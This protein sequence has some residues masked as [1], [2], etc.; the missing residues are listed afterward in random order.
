MVGRGHHAAQGAFGGESGRR[1]LP[2]LG[3]PTILPDT[4]YFRQGRRP[5]SGSR[6]AWHQCDDGTRIARETGFDRK[7][8]SVACGVHV[9]ARLG[10]GFI[11]IM[12]RLGNIGY[13][14]WRL[15]QALTIKRLVVVA[16]IVGWAVIVVLFIASDS[17]DTLR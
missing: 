10:V 13:W 8:V 7:S 17:G 11:E 2:L 4:D 5:N 16:L 3:C 12:R 6:R 14:R 9:N 1:V 15:W